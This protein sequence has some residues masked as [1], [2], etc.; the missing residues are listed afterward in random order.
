MAGVGSDTGVDT[1]TGAGSSTRL[2]GDKVGLVPVIF[3]SVTTVAPAAGV[4]TALP[5]SA[6]YAGGAFPLAVLLAA[7]ACSLIAIS[8]SQLARHLPSAGGLSTFVARGLGTVPG[9]VVGWALIFAYSCIPI[10]FWGYL[11]TI[12]IEELQKATPGAPHWLWVVFAVV[13]CVLVWA[14][15]GRGIGISS[16][17]GV[18]MGLLELAVFT[19]V[20]VVL[21]VKAGSANTVEVFKPHSGNKDGFSSVLPAAIYAI[22]AFIGFESAA[23][24]GEESANPRRNVP[25]AMLVSVTI[26]TLLYLL[27]S[28]AADV[29]VGSGRM[30]NFP[31]LG[32][33]S[34][35][36]Y[37]GE[38]VWVPIGVVIFFVLV[39]SLLANINGG[40]TAA[41]R[42]S[43]S[44]ARAGGLPNAFSRVQEPSGAPIVAIRALMVG[45]I[46]IALVLGLWLGGG[47]LAVF[48]LFATTL[49]VLVLVCYLL[50]AASCTAFYLRERRSEFRIITHVV[51][52]LLAF[53][54]LVPVL[55]AS[56]GVKFAGLDIAPVTGPARW[57]LWLAI[58]WLA[59]GLAVALYTRARRPATMHNIGQVV[60]SGQLEGGFATQ[61]QGA[62][63]GA[64]T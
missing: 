55:I 22:L 39:N 46:A 5:L 9:Y 7:V 1:G 42:M 24:I 30:N 16:R 27:T 6:Q 62:P 32:N 60:I 26:G 2:D 54:L 40:S 56:L 35:W 20:A 48:A 53:V 43:F 15:L 45:S 18:I 14:L 57:G 10:F 47:P 25:I 64:T 19:A 37:L 17:T 8:I 4:A 59:I 50:V 23:P 36:T 31:S 12:S 44:L 51:V 33:G 52:P 13:G 29:F 21:I 49:T 41:T 38:R 61:H 3:Q 11:G 28:Y 58:A 34:P 63:S